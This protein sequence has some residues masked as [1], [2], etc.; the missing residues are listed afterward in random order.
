MKKC[1][2]IFFLSVDNEEEMLILLGVPF[3][4]WDNHPKLG[5][6]NKLKSPRNNNKHNISIHYK[7][8]EINFFQL[9]V[10]FKKRP[11]R[12]VLKELYFLLVLKLQR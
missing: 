4:N 1:W 11:Q 6:R 7:D 10:L 3:K 5:H 12:V 2:K 8:Y 9:K